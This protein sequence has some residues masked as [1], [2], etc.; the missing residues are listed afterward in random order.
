MQFASIPGLGE[1][2][3]RLIDAVNS[4]KFPHAS[5]FQGKEGALNLP[6]SIALA[7]YF[8]C[9]N[10]GQQD[11]CGT[12]AA[13]TLSKKYIHPDTHFVFPVG[14]MKVDFKEKDEDKLRIELLKRWRA[15]IQEQPF[16]LADDWI[17]FYGGEDKQP[18]ISR[19]DGREI[20]KSL[21]LKPFQS[22]V[23]VMIIWQPELMH[24]AAANGIL[25]ILEE[26][27][28]HTYFILVSNQATQLLPTIIS[29]TQIVTIPL[30]QD[31]DIIAELK[32]TGIQDQEKIMR[33]VA[34]AEG[35]LSAALR[36]AQEQDEP[37]EPVFQDWMRSCFR[38][39]P[40]RLL[41][42][43][44]EFHAADRMN[45]R[46]LLNYGLSVLR[47]TLVIIS[48]SSALSR[49]VG[50]E[51]EFIKKFSAVMNVERISR[52]NKLIN[53]AL[54][55]LE[56]NASAKMIFMDLSLQ[57]NKVTRET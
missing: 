36:I 7:A 26:P 52:I 33:V 2:K 18:I 37:T 5:L 41:Q 21:M 34:R 54:Y 35:N 6:L 25:K 27:P 24:A 9:E 4:G 50:S 46:N 39:D 23:K 8:H 10:K 56:R 32:K 31:A 57:I 47:E 48:G 44:E 49:V 16:G 13:C 28:P 42:L 1:I 29:R 38:L 30:T 22:K 15:F 20:L 14:N 12:C 3:Q 11:A 45:Q 51:L 19:E 43:S 17:S 53:D 40:S 55:H